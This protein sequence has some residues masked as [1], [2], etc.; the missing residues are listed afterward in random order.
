L[1]QRESNI[2]FAKEL[3]AIVSGLKSGY[4][5]KRL[6]TQTDPKMNRLV[7]QLN[8]S[9]EDLHNQFEQSARAKEIPSELE[10]IRKTEHQFRKI[11]NGLP[12]LVSYWTPDLK[13]VFANDL[14]ATYFGLHPQNLKGISLREIVGPEL[15]LRAEPTI[16][17]VIKGENQIF[18]HDLLH[19]DHTTRRMRVQ[20][21]PD[22]I[23]G[24]ILGYLLVATDITENR[25]AKR[26]L[27]EAQQLAQIGTWS[28][29]IRNSRLFWSEQ[30]F[31][32]FSDE[33]GREQ[34]SF[35][36]FCSYIHKEDRQYFVNTVENCVTSGRPFDVRFR[37]LFSHKIIWLETIGKPFFDK[38][39]KVIGISGT[40]QDVTKIV[41]FEET[42]RDK[43]LQMTKLMNGIPAM[44]SHWDRNLIN[45]AANIHYFNFFGKTPEQLLG[46]H[47]S[48]LFGEKKFGDLKQYVYRALA[49]TSVSFD[50]D[51]V[52]KDGTL[53]NFQ[54]TY[55]PDISE[56]EVKGFFTVAIDVTDIRVLEA[57]IENERLKSIQN[58]KLASLGEMS[59]G[60][61]HEINNPLAVISASMSL[62]ETLKN[63]PEKFSA[64]IAM[65][66]RAIDRIVK[67]V[68]GLRK[69]S[70]ISDGANLQPVA[71]SKIIQESLGIIESK[72]KRY[73]VQIETDIR[74]D[75]HINCDEIE[76]EQVI[77]NLVNNAIDAIKDCAAKW[78]K[79]KLFSDGTEIIMQIHDSG[80]GI[81]EELVHKLFQPFFTTK[82]VGEGT[83]LGL[84]ISKG[85][86]ENH[87]AMID[88]IRNE[89]NTCFEVRFPI[90][91][92]VVRT[93]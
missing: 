26:S 8:K 43:Q 69:F 40:F 18:E 75:Q 37:S 76:I 22:T 13:C 50:M 38:L 14:Y 2:A 72:A 87:K 12:A 82:P 61:A 54:V 63:D 92:E 62:L 93:A 32:L 59:A 19:S 84:S 56:G 39:K 24:T 74:T 90:H 52:I 73:A 78:I 80:P 30:V 66:Q 16:A 79:I 33:I 88:L 23:D 64:K 36:K 70:R 49:G 34:P 17:K 42:L 89:P 45:L 15:F 55:Q 21:Q 5:T 60:V 67:I 4:F 47:Y 10:E 65:I 3:L 53:R 7:E 68:N 91:K 9:F 1:D 77:V 58:A 6:T 81:S 11:L 35:E 28:Y 86:L 57:Q 20:V 44:I 41:Q 25:E 29:D 48:N 85:I 83:G 27:A 46:T 71:L 31:E 51:H